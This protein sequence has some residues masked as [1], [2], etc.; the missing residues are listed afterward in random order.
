MTDVLAALDRLTDEALHPA[1][2]AAGLRRRHQVWS[3]GDAERGWCLI[4]LWRWRY[5]TR[6]LARFVITTT[7]WPAGAAEIQ[8]EIHGEPRSPT[9][10]GDAPF[11]G[12]PWEIAPDLYSG[13][14]RRR[15][16]RRGQHA[17]WTV[18]QDTDF[19]ALGRELDAYCTERA[20]PWGRERL[21]SDVAVAE[22]V[23]R[24]ERWDLIHALAILERAGRTDAEALARLEAVWRPD[25]RPPGLAPVLERW[26]SAE[27]DR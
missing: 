15:W 2:A 26:R 1:L 8:A 6:E 20:L 10:S 12:R 19:D 22:L 25:P 4:D 16:W 17:W 13:G 27:D 7:V 23:A 24:G 3:E 5:N 11:H 21:D 9:P 18:D 14:R